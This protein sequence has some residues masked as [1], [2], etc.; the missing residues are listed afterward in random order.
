M[1][2]R[3]VVVTIT[4]LLGKELLEEVQLPPVPIE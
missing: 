4:C 3:R 1:A 2:G